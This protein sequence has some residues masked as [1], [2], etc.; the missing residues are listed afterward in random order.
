MSDIKQSS[1]RAEKVA[2][3]I[4]AGGQGTRLYPL[5]MTRCKPAVTFGGRYRLIDIPISNS[6]NSK[7]RNIY[8]ISQFFATSLNEHIKNTFN[9]DKYQGSQINMLS[10]EETTE[11]KS[12]YKGT[13]DAVRQN[14]ENLL[15]TPI[16]YFLILSG[17]Q[18][19]SMDLEK[20]VAFAKE[21]DADLTIATLPVPRRDAPRLGLLKIDEDSF[22]TDFIE[23]PQDPK[24]LQK[25]ALHKD[26]IHHLGLDQTHSESSL[27]L[28]SMGI[29]IFKRSALEKLLTQFEGEDFGKHLI[30]AQI[31]NIGKTAAFV[32]NGYWEDIGTIKSFYDANLAL[33]QEKLGFDLYNEDN[34]IYAETLN[35]PCPRITDTHITQSI[36]C[37]GSVIRAKSITHS[38]IGVRSFIKEGTIVEDSIIMGNQIYLDPMKPVTLKPPTYQ[39]GKNCHI[40]KTI[41]DEHVS[42]GDNVSLTNPTNLQEFDGDDGVYIRDGIIVVTSG[43]SLPDG[44]AI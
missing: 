19:Y 14:L 28:A 4:L 23:K 38:M 29:Y 36:V 41:I 40:K 27:Y 13:A 32:Y 8:V 21:K 17:D 37:Q 16:E 44:F 31:E 18:L 24:I 7:I 22:V 1:K 26:F 3:I 9:L 25:Y 35:L 10:P 2:S 42:I 39:I 20:M 43:T 6:L 12:W 15:K 33:T 11:K 5:T 34:P 30:P